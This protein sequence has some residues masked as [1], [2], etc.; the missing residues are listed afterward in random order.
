MLASVLNERDWETKARGLLAN[1]ANELA[2][3][4]KYAK[5]KD[6]DGHDEFYNNCGEMFAKVTEVVV[7]GGSKSE[8]RELATVIES[9][10]TDLA[11][12]HVLAEGCISTMIDLCKKNA[13][14][15][16]KAKMKELQSS[17]SFTSGLGS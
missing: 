6:T 5:E 15:D 10:T 2:T 12:L 11:G 13:V 7:K 9:I 3:F 14:E 1:F 4:K 16:A 8:R 17:W